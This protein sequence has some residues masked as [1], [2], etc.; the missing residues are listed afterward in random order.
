MKKALQQSAWIL[1]LAV[2]LLG[3]PKLS[4]A[5]ANLFNYQTIDPDGSNAWLS[6][7]HIVQALIFIF[8]IY[9]INIFKPLDFGFGWGNKEVGK[10][11]VLTFTL[12]F[13]AGSL[14]NYVIAILAGSFQPFLYPLTLTNVFGQLGFQL[15]LSGPSEELIF[16]A[17][18]ITILALV[19]KGRFLKGKV[20]YANFTAAIIF[21]LAHVGFSFAPLALNYTLYQVILAIS[22]G[23]FYGDCFEKSGS[24][25][26]P[27]MMHSISNIIMV[28]LT[29]IA[30]LIL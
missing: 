30:T 14:A 15:L 1:L 24:I 17:F 3:V 7:H 2:I 22:L 27:M 20:S 26:Y 18:A 19:V 12:I 29:I 8:I 10:K 16:R 5:V 28:S 11:Y 21:G 23:I 6:V 13:G 25:F 9:V 4:G